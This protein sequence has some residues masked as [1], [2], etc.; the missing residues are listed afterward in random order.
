MRST[1]LGTVTGRHAGVGG[2]THHRPFLLTR[3]GRLARRGGDIARAWRAGMRARAWVCARAGLDR[4]SP[5]PPTLV[6]ALLA[7]LAG[8]W[9]KKWEGSLTSRGVSAPGDTTRRPNH[10]KRGARSIGRQIESAPRGWKEGRR[11]RD[12]RRQQRECRR[13]GM[14]VRRRAA[15]SSSSTQDPRIGVS[16]HAPRQ[17]D[18]L[19]LRSVARCGSDDPT[20]R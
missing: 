8:G 18:R 17:I 5:F 19:T 2:Q 13:L 20:I 11:A 12:C 1:K 3:V 6:A 16:R 14:L 7:C 4:A 15:I 10:P 9:E